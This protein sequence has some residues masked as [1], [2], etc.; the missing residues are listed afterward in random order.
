MD[1]LAEEGKGDMRLS[2]ASAF[3]W[4]KIERSGAGNHGVF[5]L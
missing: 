3:G 5:T 1:P 4:G 2:G